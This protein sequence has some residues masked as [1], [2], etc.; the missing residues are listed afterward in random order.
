MCA[1]AWL[2]RRRRCGSTLPCCSPLSQMVGRSQQSRVR[3]MSR[4]GV[5]PNHP[6]RPVSFAPAACSAPS[7]AAGGAG[8]GAGNGC[9]G[10]AAAA[11]SV[12]T[13]AT[14]ATGAAV[15]AAC[16]SGDGAGTGEGAALSSIGSWATGGMT[17][18]GGISAGTAAG[19]VYRQWMPPVRSHSWL[20]GCRSGCAPPQ[21]LARHLGSCWRCA[22]CS[23]STGSMSPLQY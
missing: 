5:S 13:S 8:D 11:P 21:L 17:W 9:T 2:R 6:H 15:A 20:C 1:P 19:I 7:G 4:W 14:A 22:H 18:T 10:T 23:L 16:W 12:A 3:T